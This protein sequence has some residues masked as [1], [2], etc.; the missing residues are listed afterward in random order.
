MTLTFD[1]ADDLWTYMAIPTNSHTSF[2]G[3]R[4]LN[5][6]SIWAKPKPTVFYLNNL[7]LPNRHKRPHWFIK[8]Q[9]FCCF[10]TMRFC[11]VTQRTVLNGPKLKWKQML[12]YLWTFSSCLSQR[13][14]KKG[15]NCFLSSELKVIVEWI[16]WPWKL[17]FHTESLQVV[18]DGFSLKKQQHLN[19]QQR[20]RILHQTKANYY[21]YWWWRWC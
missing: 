4:N 19:I 16:I 6:S 12:N 17:F 11:D 5:T 8:I 3:P 14:N 2:W 18:A 9:L 1:I 21:Y 13:A 7:N 10:W 15:T 20:S